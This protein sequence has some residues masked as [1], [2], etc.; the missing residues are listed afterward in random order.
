MSGRVAARIS[1]KCNEN[2]S[3]NGPVNG[4]SKAAKCP[5]V[6]RSGKIKNAQAQGKTLE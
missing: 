4:E 2:K 5:H 1:F 6:L 3:P